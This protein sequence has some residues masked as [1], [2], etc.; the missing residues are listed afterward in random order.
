MKKIFLFCVLF[1]FYSLAFG[2]N[3]LIKGKIRNSDGDFVPF[4][5]IGIRHKAIGTISNERGYFELSIPL[6]YQTDT[7]LIS[8]LG[9]RV[10]KNLISK[11]LAQ[12]TALIL[13]QTQSVVL[14]EVQIKVLL[15]NPELILKRVFQNIKKNYETKKF[16][17]EGFYREVIKKDENFAMLNEA[18]FRM[19]DRNFAKGQRANNPRRL[20]L[21]A[22]RKSNDYREMD[23][24]DKRYE[25]RF[26]R[27][28][29]ER[30]LLYDF[31]RFHRT[32]SVSW[33]SGFA[34]KKNLKYYDYTL[35]SMSVYD[36]ELAYCL[37]IN[38]KNKSIEHLIRLVIRADN[39]AVVEI[40]SGWKGAKSNFF[41]WGLGNY[42][43][44][45]K[46]KEYKGKYYLHYLNQFGSMIGGNKNKASF[47][48]FEKE[49]YLRGEKFDSLA[50][51]YFDQ[52]LDPNKDN[53]L[54]FSELIITKVQNNKEKINRIPQKENLFADSLS[55]PLYQYEMPYLPEKWKTPYL[56]HQIVREAW[57]DLEKRK[58]LEEQFRQNGLK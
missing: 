41:D 58:N 9:H 34:N 30:L 4:A 11:L 20:R 31:M 33:Y 53:Y 26:W 28:G 45:V 10:S 32:E 21:E 56:P 22:L 5:N 6:S 47:V 44:I 1:I 37:S 50:L 46:Y 57:A 43:S 15:D 54:Y 51:P 42:R 25:K 23:T 12:D 36:G 38:P 52:K 49:K 14:K 55:I 2:Q 17:L 13:L 39:F 16:G 24:L 48:Q 18:L 40:W 35:D 8:S 7:L 29:L 3:L 27:N 19:T